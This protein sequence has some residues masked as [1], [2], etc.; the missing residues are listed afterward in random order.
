[1][2]CISCSVKAIHQFIAGKYCYKRVFTQW[3]SA[4]EKWYG[5]KFTF[6]WPN[7]W[8]SSTQGAREVAQQGER[9][10]KR[11]SLMGPSASKQTFIL[12]PVIIWRA[13]IQEEEEEEA[14]TLVKCDI[15]LDRGAGC[16]R[17]RNTMWV[18]GRKLM[19]G[20]EMSL[21]IYRVTSWLDV[22]VLWLKTK[23]S[24]SLSLCLCLSLW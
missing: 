20:E 9:I 3:V 19:V 10:T 7:D 14:V 24:L 18:G 5:C 1:M 17:W 11:S 16:V 15:D 4:V 6:L 21:F 13:D 23:V 2:L 22:I 8:G 12:L